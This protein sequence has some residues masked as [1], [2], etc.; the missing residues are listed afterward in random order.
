ML[1]CD[2]NQRLLLLQE[3]SVTAASLLVTLKKGDE[4]PEKKRKIVSLIQCLRYGKLACKITMFNTV[5]YYILIIL[6]IKH[7][8]REI[9]HGR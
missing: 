2:K 3:T 6:M 8:N 5:L 7:E 1:L 9:I 4:A